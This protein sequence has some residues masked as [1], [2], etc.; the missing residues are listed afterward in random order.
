M[1]FS[2]LFLLTQALVIHLCLRHPNL[3][4]SHCEASQIVPVWV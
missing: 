4:H 1:E 2:F 3:G